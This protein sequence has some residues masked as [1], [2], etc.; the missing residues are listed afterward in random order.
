L[1]DTA[2]FAVSMKPKPMKGLRKWEKKDWQNFIP[3]VTEQ[4]IVVNTTYILLPIA[5]DIIAEFQEMYDLEIMY[6][7]STPTKSCSISQTKFLNGRQI[8]F[9][10]ARCC[11]PDTGN[12]TPVVRAK[13]YKKEDPEKEDYHFY[14]ARMV[15]VWLH[16]HDCKL[17]NNNAPQ[18]DKLLGFGDSTPPGKAY[19]IIPSTSSRLDRLRNMA[20]GGYIK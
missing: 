3:A 15:E 4:Q 10:C 14:F 2:I 19:E 11:D 9:Y 7:Q 1:T 18:K 12:F 20:Y 13:F 5:T 8:I 17:C 16:N 6:A